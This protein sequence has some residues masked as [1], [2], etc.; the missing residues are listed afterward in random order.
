MIDRSG[1]TEI[2]PS[3]RDAA[4]AFLRDW[5]SSE[6]KRRYRSMIAENP[7]GWPADPHFAD[8]IIV[9][10]ALRGNG[11]DEKVLGVRNLESV[12]ADLLKRAVQEP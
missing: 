5:L 7:D 6:A 3:V 2:D 12:W 8:G 10:H 1:P 11:I 4:V 9:K